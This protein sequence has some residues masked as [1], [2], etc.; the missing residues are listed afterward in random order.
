LLS[1]IDR[2]RRLAAGADAAGC[3]HSDVHV[4]TGPLDRALAG[5]SALVM[6]R[7]RLA[8]AVL[9]VGG[10]FSVAIW[11]GAALVALEMLT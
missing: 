6:D 10:A 11:M 2:Q 8:F 3:P 9:I 7:H 5:V 4:A 1:D